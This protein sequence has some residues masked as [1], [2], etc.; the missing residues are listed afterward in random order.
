LPQSEEERR[1]ERESHPDWPRLNALSQSIEAVSRGMVEATTDAEAR[2]FESRLGMLEQEKMALSEAVNERRSWHFDEDHNESRWWHVQLTRLIAELEGLVD[3]QG[4]LLSDKESSVVPPLGW[5]IPRRL[6]FARKL[7]QGFSEG[8]D[9]ARAWSSALPAIREH[10]QN[11]RISAQMGLLPIG[12]DPDSGLWEFAHLASGVPPL[13]GSDDR[14]LLRE[15]TGIVLVLIPGGT[16]WMGAQSSD[17]AGPN[18][19]EWAEADEGP[20]HEVWL[21]PF[22]LSKYELTQAQYAQ[23]TGVNPSRYNASRYLKSYNREGREFSALH[24]VERMEWRTSRKVLRRFGL[25][26]P[27]EAQWEYGC[28]AGATGTWSFGSSEES[29][30]G[31]ANVG[32]LYGREYLDARWPQME[33]SLDDGEAIHAAVGRFRANAF[34]LHDMHGNVQEWCLDG[35]DSDFYS[36]SPRRDPVAPWDLGLVRSL[37]GGSYFLLAIRARSACR[38]SVAV[39]D[40]SPDSGVRPARA[41]AD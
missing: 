1:F 16:F 6:A 5:S 40:V 37:R 34:G 26:L 11:D 18:F 20:V 41:L 17:P 29:L 27:S 32:D 4:G 13:R 3:P 19:D 23:L 21:S 22:F 7:E 35:Y 9:F 2:S 14:L 36:E 33:A 39:T 30:Q 31:A 12:L 15:W 24:P 25:D 8:G 38:T 10:Y 28:R